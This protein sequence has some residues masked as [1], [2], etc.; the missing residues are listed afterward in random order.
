MKKLLL[1]A[2]LVGGLAV[3]A[4]CCESKANPY[5]P[6]C[7]PVQCVQPAPCPTPVQCPPAPPPPPAAV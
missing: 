7:P 1:A 5:A 4:G 3:M 2:A 6:V